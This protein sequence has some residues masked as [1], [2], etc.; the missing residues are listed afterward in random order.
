M[1][2]LVIGVFKDT[3]EAGK[4]VATLKEAGF[5]QD[6][7]V[8]AKDEDYFGQVSTHNVKN[9]SGIKGGAVG[10]VIGGMAGLIAGVSSIFIPGI[11]P[12]LVAG[13]VTAL[14]TAAGV[15][16]GGFWGTL[17]NAGLAEEVA[18]YYENAIM[19]GEV[20]VAVAASPDS[21]ARVRSIITSHDG[22][23]A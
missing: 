2:H 4:A 3:L 15:L 10:A 22:I 14:F 23:M 9:D 20:L 18:K 21:E 5:T 6:I 16:A 12:L 11:G 7:S 8:I 17:A 19:R 13:P 1:S